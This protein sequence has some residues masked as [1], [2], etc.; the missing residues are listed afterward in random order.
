MKYDRQHIVEVFSRC[1][2]IVKT[3]AEI[4]A[5]RQTVANVVQGL[6]LAAK[7]PTY[8]PH[9]LDPKIVENLYHDQNL[10]TAEISDRLG[11]SPETVRM[12]MK[13]YNIPRRSHGARHGEKNHGW[14]GGRIVDKHGYI[15]IHLPGHPGSNSNG[16]IRE[17]RLV[18]EQ[19]LGRSLLPLEV[20]HHLDSNPQNNDPDN[21]EIY[22][23]NG[24][25]L[26]DELTGRC[27]QWSEEGKERICQATL[28]SIPLRPP[29]TE[30]RRQ[31]ARERMLNRQRTAKGIVI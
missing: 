18:M 6:G 1:Q 11:A 31:K 10:S 2:S 24:D 9:H 28:R 20:V 26:R 5:S 12:C 13:K 23:K 16:Y 14:N 17:H 22:S 4:G 30:E 21:L 19:K 15:L 25:H 7:K 8:S 27:P 3:A 29:W